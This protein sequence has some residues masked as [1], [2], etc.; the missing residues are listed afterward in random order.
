MAELHLQSSQSQGQLRHDPILREQAVLLHEKWRVEE[1]KR[2]TEVRTQK[3]A[4]NKA[5]AEVRAR[6]K[7]LSTHE[8][9]LQQARTPL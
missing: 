2:A 9:L 5:Q 3:Q 4:L 6:L 1:S 7:Q 8:N